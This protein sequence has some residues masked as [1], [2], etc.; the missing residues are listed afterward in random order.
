MSTLNPFT[1]EVYP[2]RIRRDYVIS[3]WSYRHPNLNPTDT[4]M[5]SLSADPAEQLLRPVEGRI[6]NGRL[7]DNDAPDVYRAMTG[8]ESTAPA[9]LAQLTVDRNVALERYGANHPLTA[10]KSLM[11]ANFNN[12]PEKVRQ[13]HE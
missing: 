5:H 13:I 8:T 3:D 12:R 4:F 10:Y 1:Q 11:I 2:T 6:L 7:Y 9:L